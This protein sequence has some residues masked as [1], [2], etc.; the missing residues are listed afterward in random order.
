MAKIGTVDCNSSKSGSYPFKLE[1]RFSINRTEK[2]I[3]D[4]KYF[5]VFIIPWILCYALFYYIIRDQYK[6]FLF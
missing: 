2:I 4:F 6:L 1:L 5:F 3:A